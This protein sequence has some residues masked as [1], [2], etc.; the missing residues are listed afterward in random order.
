[1]FERVSIR[2][3]EFAPAR[4]CA[5]LAGYTHSAFRRVLAEFGGCGALWTEM[6]SARHLLGEN[7]ATSPYLRR[8]P[9]EPRLIYQLM[10]RDNDP[11][12]RVVARLAT[13]SPDGID[14]NLACHAPAIRQLDAGSRLFEDAAALARVLKL[15]RSCWA[16]PLFAKIRLGRGDEGWRERFIERVR[17]LEGEGVDAVTVHPRF[18][19]DKFKRRVRH[20]E[21]PWIVAQT[22]LPVIANGDLDSPAVVRAEAPR[23]EGAAALMIGRMA[24]AR[25]WVFAAWDGPVAIDPRAVWMRMADELETDFAPPQALGR[26]R[27][28]TRYYGRNFAFG[29]TLWRGVHN[30]ADLLAAR[31]AADRFFATDHPLVEHPSMQGL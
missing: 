23:L 20:E 1:M 12:D 14:L 28:F 26:L 15:L 16:G 17:I 10:V 24:V 6:L 3:V 2:G 11:L 18:F 4:F 25:P 5:P 27:L 21:F 31:D 9:R 22:R 7:L 13:L 8:S 29:H 30:A 19:E